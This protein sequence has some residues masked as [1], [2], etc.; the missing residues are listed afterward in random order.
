MQVISAIDELRRTVQAWR[1][2]DLQIGFVPTMGNLH[3][4]HLALFNEAARHS[5]RVVGSIFV[6]PLQ[7]DEESDLLS[8][9]RTLAAD[10]AQLENIGVDVL[11]TPTEASLYPHGREALTRVEVVGLG[12]ILEG[13]A[14]PGHFVG[15]TTVVAKLFNCVQPDLAVFGEKDFQQLLLVRRL[16]ADLNMP[17]RLLG[18]ATVREADGLAMSSRNQRLSTDERKIAPLLY[19]ELHAIRQRLLYENNDYAVLEQVAIERL[20]DAG[21]APEY[22]AIRDADTLLSINDNTENRVILAAARLGDTRLIDNL[23]V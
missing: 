20:T 11:F 9:P 16:V 21:F 15:M 18:L 6:N 13:A 2:A 12:D 14:R 1:K 3:C 22:V 23:R 10:I 7:F 5:Q 17:I 8:Y 19:R 4:G